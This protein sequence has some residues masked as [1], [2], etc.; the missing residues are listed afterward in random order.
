MRETARREK[1]TWIVCSFESTEYTVAFEKL[2]QQS[3][4]HI[5]TRHY[6]CGR[7]NDPWIELTSLRFSAT[8]MSLEVKILRYHFA[9][10]NLFYWSLQ[11]LCDLYFFD[12]LFQRLKTAIARVIFEM[13]QSLFFY[14][15]CD[16]LAFYHLC[17]TCR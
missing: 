3:I 15:E 4:I 2:L 13:Y 12:V 11:S 10:L 17:K 16:Q 1:I 14:I 5:F 8:L 9:T 6:Y 7:C